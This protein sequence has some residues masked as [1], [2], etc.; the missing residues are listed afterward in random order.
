LRARCWSE[1]GRLYVDTNR[2]QSSGALS[3]IAGADA[4]AIVRPG[5]TARAAGEQIEIIRWDSSGLGA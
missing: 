2:I 5:H 1:D 4:L 3:S